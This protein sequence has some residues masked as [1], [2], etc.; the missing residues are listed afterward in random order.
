MA[1]APLLWAALAGL[2]PYPVTIPWG[3]L[4]A[5]F[6]YRKD[7][8]LN[9]KF[10]N[11][12]GPPGTRALKVYFDSPVGGKVPG[13]LLLPERPPRREKMPCILFLH[14]HGGRKEHAFLLKDLVASGYV[15]AAIDAVYH[16]ERNVKGRTIYMT[17]LEDTVRAITQTV[18]D[19]RRMLDLLESRPEVDKKRVGLVGGSMGALI[20]ALVAAVDERIKTAVLIVGGGDYR[21]IVKRSIHPAAA[22]MRAEMRRRGLSLDDL[23]RIAAPVDPILFGPH[24]SPRPVLMICG[25]HDRIVPADAGRALYEA[26]REPKAIYWAD[27]GHAVPGEIVLRYTKAWLDF[28]LLGKGKLPPEITPRS[29]EGQRP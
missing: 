27:S 10:A 12:P 20:G 18:I 28:W 23:A 16:G 9:L 8:P 13:L 25:K 5:R 11:C 6:E 21:I 7:A 15:V 24:I 1:P 3:R 17:S 2:G 19:N 26:L 4:K 29:I 14:G 22:Y